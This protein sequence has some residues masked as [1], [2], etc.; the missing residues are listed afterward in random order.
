[1]ANYKLLTH[2]STGSSSELMFTAGATNTVVS[3]I[4]AKDGSGQTAEVLIQKGGT[5]TVIEMA[6][7]DLTSNA[8]FQIIDVAFAIEATDKLFIRAT[9]GGMK[10]IMSYVEETELPNDTALG[11]LVDVSTSGATDGQSL[12][13]SITS[14]QWEP[15]TI[16]GGGGGGSSSGSGGGGGCA[17]VASAPSG[18][19]QAI[20]SRRVPG[21][22]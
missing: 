19:A 4:T 8:G 11:G 1:M 17:S 3:S 12:V 16:T 21:G 22:R 2:E 9:R 13:Y 20:A 14:S 7:V 15:A 18:H 6:E 5:G 10:F